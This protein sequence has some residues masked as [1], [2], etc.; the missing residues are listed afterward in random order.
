MS[1]GILD[2]LNDIKYSSSSKK[3]KHE[4]FFYFHS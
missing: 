2:S 1:A 3:T 4:L